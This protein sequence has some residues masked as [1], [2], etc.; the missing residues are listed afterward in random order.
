M[1]P[2]IYLRSDEAELITGKYRFYYGFRVLSGN[3][4][5]DSKPDEFSFCAWVN[6]K[7]KM[8]IPT[9]QLDDLGNM[10]GP[11]EYLLAGIAKFLSR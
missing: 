5:D 8:R 4:G 2:Q 1:T 3:P 6:G 7:E 10:Q 11:T 9:T